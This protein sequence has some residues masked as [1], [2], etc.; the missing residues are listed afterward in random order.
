MSRECIVGVVICES[1][2]GEFDAARMSDGGVAL[3]HHDLDAMAELD[4]VSTMLSLLI[5]DGHAPA[6]AFTYWQ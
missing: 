1:G 2:E 6:D 4:V 5:R 3:K